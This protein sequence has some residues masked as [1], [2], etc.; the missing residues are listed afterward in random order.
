M[1]VFIA[2][3]WPFLIAADPDDASL[4]A[5]ARATTG[6]LL[7]ALAVAAVLRARTASAKS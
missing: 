3:G 7:L 6:V 4:R 5:L 2:F 1:G